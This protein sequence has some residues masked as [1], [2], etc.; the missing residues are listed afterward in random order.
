MWQDNGGWGHA[1]SADLAHWEQLPKPYAEAILGPNAWDGSLTI[2]D[3]KPVAL[4]DCTDPARDR[5]GHQASCSGL[6]VTNNTADAVGAAI[7]DP[8]FIGIA[9]PADLTDPN[10]TVWNKDPTAPITFLNETGGKAAGYSGPSPIWTTPD[11]VMNLV[12]TYGAGH[13]GLFCCTDP[14]KY[15]SN[16]SWINRG[17]DQSR[18]GFMLI[19]WL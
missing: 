5:V 1:I 12:Q 10:L 4:F 19:D 17:L 2:L 14:S 13:T 16:H 6:N 3:G 18:A 8:S 7:G 15:T 9:R 11:G